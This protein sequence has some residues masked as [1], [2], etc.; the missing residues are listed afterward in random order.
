M[1]GK[2]QSSYTFKNYPCLGYATDITFQQ[3]FRPSGSIEEGNNYFSEKHKLYGLRV[4][5]S[6]CSSGYSLLFS[7]YQPGSVLKI[8][9]LYQM[10]ASHRM[11][12]E[13]LER[14]IYLTDIGPEA[15]EY[16]GY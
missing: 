4:E 10:G 13:K 15:D 16:D 6:V 3:C 8:Y 14:E 2:V 12:T 1:N 5:V 7:N 9:I 11:A